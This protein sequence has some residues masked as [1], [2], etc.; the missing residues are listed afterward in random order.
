LEET[1]PN[2]LSIRVA[3]VSRT[4]L[5]NC[6]LLYFEVE[7]LTHS[8]LFGLIKISLLAEDDYFVASLGRSQVAWPWGRWW[9]GCS[10]SVLP[11]LVLV[12]TNVLSFSERTGGKSKL[13]SILHPGK[14]QTALVIPET[15]RGHGAFM[16]YQY[17]CW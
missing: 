12:G 5:E 17:L 4:W 1:P 3:A 10:D 9:E 15:K 7:K 11:S 16:A 13:F 8:F 2:N 6:H 14:D